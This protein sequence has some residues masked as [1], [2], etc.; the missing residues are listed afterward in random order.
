MEGNSNAE[1]DRW[2]DQYIVANHLNIAE[3]IVNG[4]VCG[5]FYEITI[6]QFLDKSKE[7][8]AWHDVIKKKLIML[9][10][11]GQSPIPFLRIFCENAIKLRYPM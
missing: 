4:I 5:Q 3:K 11:A 1:Y 2:I 9:A 10:D 6:K 8:D 7:V